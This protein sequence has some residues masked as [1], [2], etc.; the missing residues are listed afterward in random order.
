[1]ISESVKD[2]LNRLPLDEVM[3]NNGY[4]FYGE[5]K[6]KEKRY[7]M[8]ACPFHGDSDPSFRVDIAPAKGKQYCG[9]YCF[10][11]KGASFLGRRSIKG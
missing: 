1:M 11:C 4:L 2:T 5:S 9:T 7:K 3:E 6:N 8:Y 10:A